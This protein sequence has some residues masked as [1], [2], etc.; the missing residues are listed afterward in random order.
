MVQGLPDSL[1]RKRTTRLRD[2][3]ALA[4]GQPRRQGVQIGNCLQ[5]HE[6]AEQTQEKIKEVWLTLHKQSCFMV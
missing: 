3:G 4:L 1:R 6:E 5:T 2:R